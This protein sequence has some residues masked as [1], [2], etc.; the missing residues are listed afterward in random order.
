MQ[1]ESIIKSFLIK[2]IEKFSTKWRTMYQRQLWQI[3]L[4]QMTTMR[5]MSSLQF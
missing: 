2:V 1:Y 3:S 5:T 4:R